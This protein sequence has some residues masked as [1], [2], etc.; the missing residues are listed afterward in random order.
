M[1]IQWYFR[2]WF[3]TMITTSLKRWSWCSR[4]WQA[5]K[6]I[7]WQAN[8]HHQ[9][10]NIAFEIIKNE[11]KTNQIYI[12]HFS[13]GSWWILFPLFM[14]ILPL[15]EHIC[16]LMNIFAFLWIFLHA[17]GEAGSWWIEQIGSWSQFSGSH[18]AQK[19]WHKMETRNI[20]K[21]KYACYA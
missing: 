8:H 16:L 7:S 10:K 6:Q 5:S 3:E 13:N 12:F 2:G 21:Y 18:L 1:L 11:E 19:Y 9:K 20:H 4:L 14:N 17:V 15:F